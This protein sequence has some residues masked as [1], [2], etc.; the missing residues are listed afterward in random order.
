MRFCRYGRVLLVVF[1]L[2]L[3]ARPASAEA[4]RCSFAGGFRLLH[5]A[6]PA[7]VGSCTSAEYYSANG[8]GLQRTSRGLLVWRKGENI[9]A[10][11]DGYRTWINGPFG[12][13]TRLNSQRF[14]WEIDATASCLQP[15]SPLCRVGPPL[16]NVHDPGRL[17]VIA[18]CAVAEGTVTSVHHEP[19]GD[20]FTLLRL[21]P[22]QA[23]LLN[24]T[25]RREVDG[26]LVAEIVPA[27]QPGCTVGRSPRPPFGTASFGI[28]TGAALP[29]PAVGEHISVVG[30]HV[31][32]R[33]HGWLEIHPV[34]AIRP[35]SDGT[36]TRIQ[37]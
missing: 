8:D 19:D 34:W 17:R 12:I 4:A 2:V 10:F 16:A 3:F 1:G 20:V 28:C 11:T 5:D 9:T 35:A 25:N 14:C 30:P 21:A 13:Q 24:Q 27:D 37:R 7:V 29:T 31:L 22:G 6:L 26:N 15:I 36:G 23:S 18:R 32:D 33:E